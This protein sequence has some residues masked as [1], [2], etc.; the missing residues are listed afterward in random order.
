MFGQLIIMI[1]YLPILT[2]QGVEGKM[3]RPMALTVMFVLTGSLILSLTLM[4]VVAS[5]VLPTHI[6]E[7]DSLPVAGPA[8]CTRRARSYV[9]TSA[10]WSWL[11]PGADWHWRRHGP[12]VWV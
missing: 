8:H 5:L 7:R 10:S 2:L 4:P 3:F 6:E 1:V 12:V 11:W 9:C